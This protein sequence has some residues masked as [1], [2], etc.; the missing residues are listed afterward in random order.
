MLLDIPDEPAIATWTDIDLVFPYYSALVATVRAISP[1]P[2]TISPYLSGARTYN[3]TP[4]VVAQQAQLF[5]EN[6]GIGTFKY[7]KTALELMLLM[8]V[9]FS[10]PN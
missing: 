9:Q 8:Y 5:A 2:I 10:W 7:G 1:L 3:V 4:A 6:T